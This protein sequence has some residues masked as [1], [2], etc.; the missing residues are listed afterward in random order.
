[1]NPAWLIVGWSALV[2]VLVLV[3]VLTLWRAKLPVS[4]NDDSSDPYDLTYSYGNSD[5]D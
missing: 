3:L 2:L 4:K 5:M 1:M